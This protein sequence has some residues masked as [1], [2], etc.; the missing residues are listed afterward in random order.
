MR[1][2]DRESKREREKECEREKRERE[3][4]REAWIA[5]G[6]A[7]DNLIDSVGCYL[8]GSRIMLLVN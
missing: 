2:S 4:E 6:Y 8:M 5:P 3:R 1:E 7:A